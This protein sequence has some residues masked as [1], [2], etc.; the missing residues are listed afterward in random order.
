[1]AMHTSR[2]CPF[3]APSPAGASDARAS[4]LVEHARDFDLQL[5]RVRGG[6][7][8]RLVAQGSSH[9]NLLQSLYPLQILHKRALAVNH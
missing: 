9:A 6:Q 4:R 5:L 8:G 7:G 3:I 1:M 2:V